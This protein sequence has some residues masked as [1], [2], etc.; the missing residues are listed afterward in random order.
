MKKSLAL[1]LTDLSSRLDETE[2][3][4]KRTF[5]TFSD[6]ASWVG[7]YTLI[8]KSRKVIHD[9]RLYGYSLDRNQELTQI[10][11]GIKIIETE[12]IMRALS[13]SH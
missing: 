11:D 2:I 1:R 7:V 3:A 12:L 4:A 10:E 13:S 6:G 5:T 8:K 9:T